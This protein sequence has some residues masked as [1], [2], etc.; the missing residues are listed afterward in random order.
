[1]L[2]SDYYSKS[3]AASLATQ[4]SLDISGCLLARSEDTQAG[5]GYVFLEPDGA[6]SSIVVGGANA[7]WDVGNASALEAHF[8]SL[9]TDSSLVMLQREI[10]EAV[11]LIAARAARAAGVPVI[12][13]LGG[14]D[15]PLSPELL[16]NIS[17]LSPNEN[18][19][20]R[21]TSM[22]T[23]TDTQAV[24]AAR[25][26]QMIG[27]NK[28]AI[29]VT[30]GSRGSFFLP[31]PT[32]SNPLP[33]SI[34]QEVHPI[35]GDRV[36][37]A[38]SAGDSFRAAFSVCLVEHRLTHHREQDEAASSEVKECLMFASSAG[39]LAVSKKGAMPSL[40]YRS[41]VDRWLEGSVRGDNLT[42]FNCES[43]PSTSSEQV[44][45]NLDHECPLDFASRLN[46]MKARP[47][48]FSIGRLSNLLPD[49]IKRQGMV[50]GL[51]SIHLNYPEHHLLERNTSLIKAAMAEAGMKAGA[52]NIRFPKEDFLHGSFTSPREEIRKKA[53]E[54][55]LQGCRWARELGAS[56]LVVWSQFDG[57]DYLLSMDYVSSWQQIVQSY[58]EL[59]DSCN[60]K[61]SIEPKPTDELARFSIVPSTSA[62]LLL[63]RDVNRLNFGLTLDY[64]HA[65]L[66][67][68]NP[69]QLVAMAISQGKLFGIH[70]NDG[71]SRLG[72]EDGLAFGSVSM[73]SA[74]ETVYWLRR[75]NYQGSIYFDTFPMREDPV[76]EAELNIKTF[77][78]LWRSSAL[79]LNDE[80]ENLL[81]EQDSMKILNYLSTKLGM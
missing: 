74:L 49:L 32:P 57:G 21:I 56:D 44:T 30:L 42:T 4:G 65:L 19:L 15:S 45:S 35:P 79:L 59:C 43:Q 27:L 2:G 22:P 28:Q 72:A 77:K 66:A 8:T 60:L 39:A 1:M 69:G 29:L 12:L 53:V 55:T 6:A 48:L 61:I 81:R 40:P 37:D 24:E 50:Q 80:F 34:W 20:Q 17:I 47:D 63:I 16:D 26:L 7:A 54:L 76:E 70:L 78:K 71:Y 46:S 10:P 36:V 64:G 62:A 3:L 25:A 11:N 38:T 23:D 13:D 73:K 9:V 18:E 52:V 14:E 67:S 75:L 31:Y 58:Q 5:Q 33:T 51:H 41:D 68:E